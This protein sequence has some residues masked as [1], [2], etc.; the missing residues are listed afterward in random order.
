MRSPM[1][2]HIKFLT[3]SHVVA[4]PSSAKDE[5]VDTYHRFDLAYKA[6]DDNPGRTWVQFF[7]EKDVTATILAGEA[8]IRNNEEELR[9]KTIEGKFY[10]NVLSRHLI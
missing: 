9:L 7:A 3:N 5:D 1:K 4:P 8:A 10:R 6:S 2:R